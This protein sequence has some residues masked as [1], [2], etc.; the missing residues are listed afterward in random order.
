[1]SFF[2]DVVCI[3]SIKLSI[4]Y[5]TKSKVRNAKSMML[6]PYHKMLNFIAHFACILV[7]ISIKITP[8]TFGNLD[9]YFTFMSGKKY[10]AFT[11]CTQ[12]MPTFSHCALHVRTIRYDTI[13]LVEI[14]FK[15]KTFNKF[16]HTYKKRCCDTALSPFLCFVCT[17]FVLIS[18]S[19]CTMRRRRKNLNQINKFS[20][21]IV[22][23]AKRQQPEDNNKMHLYE[24]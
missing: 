18:L 20:I 1:M 11:Y 9:H 24:S 13:P 19:C 3:I 16:R 14:K 23:K 6:M 2:N 7:K 15:K 10:V 8:F 17:V 5:V 21:L 12:L 4:S 22:K